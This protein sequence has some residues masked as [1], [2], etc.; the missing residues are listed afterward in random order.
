LTVGV[1]SR[2]S[3]KACHSERHPAT[4]RIKTILSALTDGPHFPD[5]P[6][7]INDHQSGFYGW[8]EWLCFVIRKNETTRIFV[9]LAGTASGLIQK[10]IHDIMTMRHVG[11]YVWK[12]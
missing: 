12:R 1:L 2:Q 11:M 5:P 8:L 7:A 4:K 6:H 3:K 10:E 9:D